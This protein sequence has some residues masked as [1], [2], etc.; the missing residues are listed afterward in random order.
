MRD[1]YTN[2]EL[3]EWFRNKARLAS[4]GEARK[5]LLAAETRQDSIAFPGKLYFYKYDAK[6]K[7][8]LPM[9]D[10]YPLCMVLERVS[11]GFIGLNLHYLPKAQRMT[12]LHGFD[13]YAK[14]V[15]L[16]T[17]VTT[18]RY[19]S[20]WQLLIKSFSTMG[21]ESLPKKCIK[22]YLFTHVKSKFVEI[23]PNEFDKAVLLPIDLWVF[24][25]I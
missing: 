12:L 10:K 21:I 8:V 17:G 7:D 15:D 18:G 23:Y 24:K 1:D 2:D 14:N 20:N 25:D 6:T 5:Q 11:G 3:A 4:S 16:E 22:R 13:K 19:A 9:W